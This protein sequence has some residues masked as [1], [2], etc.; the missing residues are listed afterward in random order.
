MLQQV[1]T[2][3][4]EPIMYVEVVCPDEFVSVILAD[5]SNRRVCIQNVT[6]KG[7]NKVSLWEANKY[8]VEIVYFYVLKTKDNWLLHYGYYVEVWVQVTI[9]VMLRCSSC[10]GE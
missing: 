5:L 10:I 6:V 7:S 4:L 9:Q 1:G 2:H 3:I 8:I